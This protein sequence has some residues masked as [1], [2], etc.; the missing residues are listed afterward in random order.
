[1]SALTAGYD[2]QG[3]LRA[4]DEHTVPVMA[5]MAVCMIATFTYLVSAFRT[6]R[7]HRA[8]PAP[9]TSVG[10]FAIHDASYVLHWNDWFDPSSPYHH[11]WTQLWA[12]ALIGT[13]MIEFALCYMV[14]RYGREELMPRLSQRMFGLTVL[15]ALAGI[16]ALWWVVKSVLNDP[17]FLIAFA[18]TAWMGAVW[19]TILFTGRGSM[20]GQTMLMNWCLLI[21]PIGM[22]GSW[23]FLDPF[24]R[25]PAF[26]LLGVSGVVWG[27][28]NLAVMRRYPPYVPPAQPAVAEESA[29]TAPR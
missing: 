28:V 21:I 25:S 4:V 18:I 2:P 7:A 15:G 12:I 19:A 17:L 22:W 26:L 23:A 6:A 8:Y 1:M 13:T 20:R 14:Y 10:F 9:L 16:A 3:V 29:A 24:F 27:S 5:C 11:W